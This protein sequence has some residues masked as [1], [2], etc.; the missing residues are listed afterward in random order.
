MGKRGKSGVN[1]K[2]GSSGLSKTFIHKSATTVYIYIYIY[3]LYIF[4]FI[5]EL[6]ATGEGGTFDFIFIDAD[7]Q[8]LDIYYEKSLQLIKTGG[9][10]A[11]DNVS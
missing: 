3:I 6:L 10:I 5:D 11:V 2:G 7:K 8:N 1:G 9:V 4:V